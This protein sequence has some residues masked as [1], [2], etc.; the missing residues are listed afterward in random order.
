VKSYSTGSIGMYGKLRCLRADERFSSGMY[1][2]ISPGR[3]MQTVGLGL[4]AR[5]PNLHKLS[6]QVWRASVES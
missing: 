2:L 4:L 3:W 5:S 1:A 6:T